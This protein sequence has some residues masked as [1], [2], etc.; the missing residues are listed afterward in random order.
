M[1]ERVHLTPPVAAVRPTTRTIHGVELIDDY[2]WM[3]DRDDPELLT[4]LEAENAY[5]D[6]MMEH[7]RALQDELFTEL[8]SHIKETDQTA[9]Y[10]SGAYLYYARTVEGLQYDI[11]CRRRGSLDAPE[12]VILDENELAAGHGYFGLG[13]YQPSPD[14][15][16]LAFSTDTEGSERYTLRIKDLTTGELLPDVI[17]NTSYSLGWA[18]DN[19]TLLYTVLD[20]AKRPFK[21]FRHVLGTDPGND[22]LVHHERDDAFFVMVW[23]S[24]SQRFLHIASHSATTSEVLVADADDPATF[25]SIAPRRHEVEYHVVDQG[26][27]FVIW[28]NDGAKN[29]RVVE[30]PLDTTSSGDWRELIGHRPAIKV[31]QITAFADHLAILERERGLTQ[32]RVQRV[33]TGEEH[34][35]AMPEPAYVVAP[36]PNDVYDTTVLRYTYQSPVIPPTAYDYDMA[37]RERT[38]VKRKE[39]PGYDPEGYATERIMVAAADGVEVP[40]TIVHR[41]DR[42]PGGPAVLYGY[43]SYGHSIEPRFVGNRLP[44]LD[45]GYAWAIAHVRGGGELGETWRDDGKLLRKRNTFTD[46]IAVAEHLVAEGIT[47]PER[48][49]AWGGSAGGLLMGGIANMRPDLFGAVIADVPFVDVVNTMLDP[50]IPL[51]VIEYEEWGNPNDAGF[52]EYIRSYSPYD[53]IEPKAYPNILV[54]SGINDPRVQYWEPTKYVA[55]LRATKTDDNVVL[56]RMEMGHGHGGPSGRYDAL[57]ELA[58]QYGF[59]LDRAGAAD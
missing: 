9:P 14:G 6:A 56:L 48:L 37:T 31:E 4:Y 40:V 58:F 57:R 1:L 16:L 3:R 41:K 59:L 10:P 47:T 15:S 25:R 49:A 27:R 44:L 45:R 43:G 5:T 33:S 17:E 2:A 51:T 13:V 29:F 8:R 42:P 21:V 38:L 11:N 32:I 46:F 50:S 52:F 20:E 30:A 28:T 18:N 12:E 7:T 22:G 35:I 23:Q 53:N 34:L 54:M 24:T 19:R 26:D 36:G 39:V 55:K